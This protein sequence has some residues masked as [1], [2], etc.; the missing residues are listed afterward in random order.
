MVMVE[1]QPGQRDRTPTCGALPLRP[2]QG[3][4]NRRPHHGKPDSHARPRRRLHAHLPRTWHLA[5]QK[6][7]FR[8]RPSE[9]RRIRRRLCD[10]DTPASWSAKPVPEL[11]ADPN[12]RPYACV[13]YLRARVQHSA[14]G[15]LRQDRPPLLARTPRRHPDRSAALAA[16]RR[17][18]AG[19]CP[20]ARLNGSHPTQT[21]SPRGTPCRPL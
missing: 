14:H 10:V 20:V 21:L 1:G 5:R 18:P 12:Q 8:P 13:R 2:P 6:D 16:H 17:P 15:C 19:G 4:P 11:A 7:P 3:K 9:R